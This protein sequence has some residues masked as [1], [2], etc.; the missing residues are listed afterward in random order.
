[1]II[2]QFIKRI[3]DKKEIKVYIFNKKN[4]ENDTLEIKRKKYCGIYW[5]L[6]NEE[7]VYIGQSQDLLCRIRSHT[8][9]NKIW[10]KVKCIEIENPKM[11]RWVEITLLKNFNTKY[12]NKKFVD[13][14]SARSR[15]LT[16]RW[17]VNFY[18]KMY[19]DK[20]SKQKKYYKEHYDCLKKV[21]ISL[22]LKLWEMDFY[23][24]E[25]NFNKMLRGE[26]FDIN[27]I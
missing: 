18:C 4:I 16:F 11:A 15:F 2:N 23:E 6:N 7:I 13:R 26:K 1:M 19:I 20:K 17:Y 12:N 5:L 27:K 22:Y 8:Y 14:I 21:D 10:N 24:F 25:D 3:L 9:T